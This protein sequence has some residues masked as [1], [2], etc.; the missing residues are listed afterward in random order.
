MASASDRIRNNVRAGV[1]VIVTITLAMAVI[2]ILGD[3]KQYFTRPARYVVTYPIA[4]GVKNLAAG[5]DVRVG[6]ISMGR[7]SQVE[8]GGAN[9]GP[10]QIIEVQFTLDRQIKL[11]TNAR[12]SVGAALIGSDAWLNITDLGG[13]EEDPNAKILADGGVIEGT[14]AAGFMEALMG[15]HGDRLENIVANVESGSQFFA[16]I[17]KYYDADFLPILDNLKT[18]TTD[19][20]EISSDVRVN[21][22][23]AWAQ[24][25]DNLMASL[26]QFGEDAKGLAQDSRDVLAENRG[27]I[28]E[29]VA[30]LQASS[31]DAKAVTARVREETMEQVHALLTT[32]QDGLNNAQDVLQRMSVDYDVWAAN[33]A[34]AL[35]NANLTSQQLKLAGIEIRRS[36]W[37]LLYRPDETELQHELL[38]EAARSF[39]MAAADL[40]ASSVAAD[41][42]LKEHPEELKSSPELMKRLQDNLIDP[43]D[44]YKKAQAELFEILKIEN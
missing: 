42:M 18:V 34:D 17:S 35:A 11:Y 25:V 23:P 29:T 26:N 1:F 20:R 7:V 43:L 15:P 41:R 6:G 21:R 14:T 19:A 38:Y 4:S 32:A 22:W 39:A 40:K 5:S 12:I 3:V 2:L 27:P 33:L 36:P 44:R 28:K 31:A 16:D 8:L 24:Q 37:K 13:T 30:N 9:S 10:A